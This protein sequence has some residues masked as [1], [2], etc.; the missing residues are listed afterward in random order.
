MIG[1]VTMP[2]LKKDQAGRD[3]SEML[4]AHLTFNEA[5]KM[6]SLSLMTRQ[7]LKIVKQGLYAQLDNLP[8]F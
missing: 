8:E 4:Q 1:F 6:P 5:L 3:F 7:R 2:A